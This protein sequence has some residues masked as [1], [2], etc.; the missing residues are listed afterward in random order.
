MRLHLRQES[1]R[2]ERM[3]VSVSSIGGGTREPPE[4]LFLV[5]QYLAKMNLCYCSG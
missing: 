1:K 4:K 3:C 5:S 2:I